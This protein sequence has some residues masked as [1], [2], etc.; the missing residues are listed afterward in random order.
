MV[1]YGRE[2]QKTSA[3]GGSPAARDGPYGWTDSSLLSIDFRVTIVQGDLCENWPVADQ[4]PSNL[5]SYRA[6][7]LIVDEG[8]VILG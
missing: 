8:L 3:G 1:V 6:F 4:R 2:A 7:P 5:N